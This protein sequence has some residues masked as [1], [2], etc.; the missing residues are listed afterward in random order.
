MGVNIFKVIFQVYKT[1]KQTIWHQI[2]I[3]RKNNNGEWKKAILNSYL[4]EKFY[5]NYIIYFIIYEY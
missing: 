5:I 2:Q 3:F 1:Y 4:W